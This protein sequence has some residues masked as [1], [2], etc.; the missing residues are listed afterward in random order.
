M[1]ALEVELDP[2]GSIGRRF[3]SKTQE[4]GRSP[5]FPF[6][7]ALI[8]PDRRSCALTRMAPSAYK[9]SHFAAALRLLAL[10]S[11][12]A[13]RGPSKGNKDG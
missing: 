7:V 9:P 12:L 10:R 13:L 1:R 3:A 8:R 11:L 4:E 6:G 5:N 2:Q